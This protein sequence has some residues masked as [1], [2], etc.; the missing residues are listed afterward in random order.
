MGELFIYLNILEYLAIFNDGQ[1]YKV[2]VEDV[3]LI[4]RRNLRAIHKIKPRL[5][6]RKGQLTIFICHA[7]FIRHSDFRELFSD[8]KPLG[9]RG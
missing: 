1:C 5:Q 2:W 6:I 8:S 7:G 9:S 3:L 4:G